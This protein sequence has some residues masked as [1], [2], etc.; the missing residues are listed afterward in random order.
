MIIVNEIIIHTMLKTISVGND[1]LILAHINND[2][3][4][5]VIK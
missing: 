1:F 5:N 4:T 2:D 3:V